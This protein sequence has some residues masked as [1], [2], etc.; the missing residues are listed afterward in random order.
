[1]HTG[2]S[3]ASWERVGIKP[4]AMSAFALSTQLSATVGLRE[5]GGLPLPGHSNLLVGAG[6]A[7]EKQ[8]V[9]MSGRTGGKTKAG[10][11]GGKRVSGK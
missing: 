3:G 8:E 6:A 10:N 5:R 1:M 11:R 4:L 9:Q 2:G 7:S